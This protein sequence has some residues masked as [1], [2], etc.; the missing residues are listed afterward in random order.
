M[1]TPKIL[2][3]TDLQLMGETWKLPLLRFQNLP[4]SVMEE[5]ETLLYDS[6]MTESGSSKFD[7]LFDEC[8]QKYPDQILHEDL[9]DI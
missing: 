9:W 6:M 2:T 5:L 8:Y 3:H 1:T 4:S 7:A